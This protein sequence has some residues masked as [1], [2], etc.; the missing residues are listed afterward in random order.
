MKLLNVVRIFEGIIMSWKE[1]MS[2]WGGG[3][4]SFLS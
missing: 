2:E 1:K 4:V 3:E